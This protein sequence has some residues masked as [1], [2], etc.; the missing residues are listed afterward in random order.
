MVGAVKKVNLTRNRRTVVVEILLVR[1]RCALQAEVIVVEL[2][3]HAEHLAE[4]SSDTSLK[5][6]AQSLVFMRVADGGGHPASDHEGVLAGTV[7]IV[8]AVGVVRPSVAA[9]GRL[10]AVEASRLEVEVLFGKCV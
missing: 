7:G 4:V 9:R 8:V 5:C 1:Q 3:K 6:P 10:G 2:E